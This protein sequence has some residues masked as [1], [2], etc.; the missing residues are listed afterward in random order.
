MGHICNNT[1]GSM[2]G[3]HPGVTFTVNLLAVFRLSIVLT[4]ATETLAS[5]IGVIL[6]ALWNISC[7]NLVEIIILYTVPR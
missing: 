7:G 4:A 1:L 5:E 6:G 2:D 3:I